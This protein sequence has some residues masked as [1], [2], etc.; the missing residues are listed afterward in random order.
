[1]PRIIAIL[2][3]LGIWGVLWVKASPP[4]GDRRWPTP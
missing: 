1:M 4:K 2:G 3:V